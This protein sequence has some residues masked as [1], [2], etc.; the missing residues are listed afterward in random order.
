MTFS[1]KSLALFDKV[2]PDL[3]RLFTAVDLIYP[4]TILT[5]AR[6]DDEEAALVAKGLSTTMHSKH[7]IQPDGFC[8]ALDV[9]PDPVDFERKDYEKDLIL[10][11]GRVMEMARSM[12]ISIRYGGLFSHTIFADCSFQDT[13]HFELI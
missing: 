11:A 2:H 3:V 13:D 6:T 9:A 1:A 12:N 8:H 5:G 10:F 4:C 7:L